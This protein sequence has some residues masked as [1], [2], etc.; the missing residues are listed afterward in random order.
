[1]CMLSAGKKGEKMSNSLKIKKLKRGKIFSNSFLSLTEN[2]TITFSNQ[3]IAVVYGPNGAGKTSITKIL[4]K[5][6]DTEYEIEYKGT[7]HTHS[8]NTIFHIISDQL[9]R[10]I[11]SG[12]TKEYF[13]GE[14]I[15]REYELHDL[16][17]NAFKALFDD[18]L[19][20]SLN[21]KFK[22]TAKSS[23]L[24]KRISD[25]KI[26]KYV[27]ALVN[28]QDK[29]RKLDK[30]EFIN[31]LKTFSRVKTQEYD[32]IILGFILSDYAKGNDSVIKI[33]DEL[34]IETLEK[35]QDYR[36]LEETDVAISILEK[37]GYR[38]ECIVCDN[39]IDPNVL[40]E[41]KKEKKEKIYLALA[42]TT[43]NILE[44]VVAK[45]SDFDPMNIGVAL[46]DAIKDGEVSGILNIKNSITKYFRIFNDELLNLF[47]E[48]SSKSEILSFVD[49]YEKILSKKPAIN[50]EDLKYI[51]EIVNENIDRIIKI[52]RDK[53]N[54]LKIYIDDT[55]LLNN[56]RENLL[57]STGEQNFISLSFE[58]LKAKNAKDKIIVIDDPISSFDS[59]YKNKIAFSLIKVLSHKNQLIFTHNTD[60][61][62]LLEHQRKDS[63][64]LYLLN[65]TPGEIN[66]F[67]PIAPKEVEL[68]LRIDKLISILRSDIS[69]YIK[70]ETYFLLSLIPFMRGYAHITGDDDSYKKLTSVMH[71][72]LSEEVDITQI[73]QKLFRQT[74]NTK[75][76]VH[77]SAKDIA[78]MKL[79]KKEILDISTWPLL[80][81]TLNHS[82]AYLH[83]RLN[84]E[85]KLV[86]KFF[87]DT[88]VNYMLTDIIMAAFDG[89]TESSMKNRV[90]LTSKKTLLNEFNH[91]EGN[92]NIFQPAIDISD[93]ALEKE[94]E[95]IDLFISKL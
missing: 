73:Y 32:E 24:V 58:L 2:N 44:N 28:N 3:G 94:K 23:P 36:V 65:K 17:E 75:T 74:N 31:S 42:A 80:N 4:S 63:F 5:E 43:K 12:E 30:N 1:M 92:M 72:Y 35:D 55:E 78:L 88:S 71:G 64:S 14:D 48:C 50:E 18:I 21:A 19:R 79:D 8:D 95:S 49:E 84:V 68:L 41:R 62:K 37:Y 82:L 87:I 89:K 39:E 59:I 90:F 93:S 86:E 40:V 61:I 67:I 57:L 53:N 46:L 16:I 38:H 45:I 70:D 7:I 51:E 6:K 11:I 52:D 60:L 56:T 91:F 54:N 25:P 33:L 9:G 29:G 26:K 15:A 47:C 69:I 83:L 77:I 20:S 22:I 13:L 34:T 85:K 27:E 81:R 10:N 76:I 66:G